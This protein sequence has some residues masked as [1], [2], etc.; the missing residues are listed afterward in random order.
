M[1]RLDAIKKLYEVLD[2]LAERC[3]GTR[4]LNGCHGRLN[5]PRRGVYFFF[6]EGEVR[7]E[8]GNGQRVVRVG[9]HALSSGSKTSLW[10][11]LSQHAGQ[12]KS[13]GGNHRG[14]IF[15]LLVGEAMKR[16]DGLTEP[17]SWGIGSHPAATAEKLAQTAGQVRSSESALEQAVSA[18]I[19]RMPFLAVAVEDDAGPDSE[20]GLIER[21]AIALLSNFGRSSL[22][23]PSPSWLGSWSG[24]NRVRE[25]GLWNNNHVDEEWSS[26]FFPIFAASAKRTAALV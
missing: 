8:S 7:R 24:R 21:N 11:R 20:R 14:S 5:W 18:Y 2:Q 19:S 17:A 9:T 16:R 13:G 22:D 15:R 3:D 23:A 26:D 1:N 4:T 12:K 25:S 10:Q 6:E